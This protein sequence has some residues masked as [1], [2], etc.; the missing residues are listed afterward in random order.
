MLM[1]HPDFSRVPESN[2][3]AELYS[4]LDMKTALEQLE[5]NST[6]RENDNDESSKFCSLTRLDLLIYCALEAV[7]QMLPGITS[8]S[9]KGYLKLPEAVLTNDG[10][11]PELHFKAMTII[12]ELQ[13]STDSLLRADTWGQ[14]TLDESAMT[15]AL[16][17]RALTSRLL[18]NAKSSSPPTEDPSNQRPQYELLRSK[19]KERTLFKERLSKA[20]YPD[21]NIDEVQI[22]IIKLDEILTRS[23]MSLAQKVHRYFQ[24]RDLE[25][26]I[27]PI[28]ERPMTDAIYLRCG[29]TVRQAA[30]Q[31]LVAGSIPASHCCCEEI[32]DDIEHKLHDSHLI[33][34]LA[35]RHLGRALGIADIVKYGDLPTVQSI[36]P[37][38]KTDE[39]KVDLLNLAILSKNLPM[40]TFFLEAGAN[41]NASPNSKTPLMCAASSGTLEIVQALLNHKA[42]VWQRDTKGR[43]A[44]TFAVYRGHQAIIEHLFMR[45][46][47]IP[48]TIAVSSDSQIPKE[49]RQMCAEAFHDLW[50]GFQKAGIAQGILYLQRAMELDSE[51]HLYA[52]EMQ[53][54]LDDLESRLSDGFYATYSGENPLFM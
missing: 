46:T 41:V 38:V 2:T 10:R 49:N 54:Y 8:L 22:A 25:S 20:P 12:C 45:M 9:C 23:T 44:L 30:L 28:S 33:R 1:Q 18:S 27:C 34:N 50:Q 37:N 40:T 36:F 7:H 4:V 52:E 15:S 11:A 29:K 39:E 24:E 51:N 53:T 17:L 43:S 3:S 19:V 6:P 31:E 16:G 13:T 5:S 21:S 47:N 32:H 42:S 35:K 48:F 14:R 26:L